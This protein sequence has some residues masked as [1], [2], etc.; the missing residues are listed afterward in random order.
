MIPKKWATKLGSIGIYWDF[1]FVRV[2]KMGRAFAHLTNFY[3]F[4]KLGNHFF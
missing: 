2:E 1:A 4:V 3:M